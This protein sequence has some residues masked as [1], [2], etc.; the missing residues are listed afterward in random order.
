MK[1]SMSNQ[2]LMALIIF[3][4]IFILSGLLKY[5]GVREGMLIGTDDNTPI[6]GKPVYHAVVSNN[7]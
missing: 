4:G 2:I 3:F 7:F 5:F 6:P 1:P